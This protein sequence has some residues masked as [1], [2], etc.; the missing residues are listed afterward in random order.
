[1]R[2]TQALAAF[3]LATVAAATG[4]DMG[5]GEGVEVGPR[6]GIVRS[7]DGRV[8]LEIPA[9][10]LTD[11]VAV[12]I[13]E[14][15]ELPNNAAGPAYAIEPYGLVF[16][17]PAELAYDVSGGLMSDTVQLVTERGGSWDALADH[18]VDAEMLE[19][20]ASVLF[21]SNVGLIE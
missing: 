19:V 6:G 9:G 14:T 3:V 20:T 11:T 4:C 15:D 5:A 7:D 10:A 2:A 1:M 12:S 8:T 16:A 13:V 18:D 17:A 21:A